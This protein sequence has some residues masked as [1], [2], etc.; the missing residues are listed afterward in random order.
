MA[1]L[2]QC[3][4]LELKTRHAGAPASLGKRHGSILIACLLQ[5]MENAVVAASTLDRLVRRCDWASS[6]KQ[7]YE[8]LTDLMVDSPANYREGLKSLQRLHLQ[9]GSSWGQGQQSDR[10]GLPPVPCA[11]A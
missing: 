5:D 8:L 6:R 11:T 3:S 4:Y 2:K 7:V 9:V 10:G 1:L